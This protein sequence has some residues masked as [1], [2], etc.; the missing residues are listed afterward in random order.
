MIQCILTGS[1]AYGKPTSKSDIDLVMLLT[2]EQLKL[3]E[4]KA[5]GPEYYASLIPG[6]EACLRFGDLNI[7][8]VTDPVA[9]AVW[10]KGTAQLEN[11]PRGISQDSKRKRAIEVLNRLRNIH[12]IRPEDEEEAEEEDSDEESETPHEEDDELEEP[13]WTAG[14]FVKYKFSGDWCYGWIERTFTRGE[15]SYAR[16]ANRHGGHNRGVPL[17]NLRHAT[18]KEVLGIEGV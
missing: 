12:G 18:K 16:V 7:I 10:Q 1:H 11:E 15:D 2:P 5:G 6:A 13:E 14:E 8:A 17:T 4:K 9:F 3:F